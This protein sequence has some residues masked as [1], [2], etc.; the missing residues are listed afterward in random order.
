[1]AFED[2]FFKNEIS[3]QLNTK[4]IIICCVPRL[5]SSSVKISFLVFVCA[6]C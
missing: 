5:F 1:M 3:A 4:T 6:L 2:H